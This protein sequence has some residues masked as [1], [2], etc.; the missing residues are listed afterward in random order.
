VRAFAI[1]SGLDAAV[2]GTIISVMPLELYR[3][4]GDAAVVSIIYFAVGCLSLLV[5][6]LVPRI[7]TLLQRRWTFTLGAALF[8]VGQTAGI[9]GGTWMVVA[10][11]ANGAG[12]VMVFV[13]LNAYVL[14]YIA[15]SDLGRTESMRMFYAALPWTVGPFLGVLLLEVWRPLPFIVAGFLALGLMGVFWIL[16]LG[17]G[18]AIARARGP[19]PNP[20]AYIGR[21]VQQP[22]LIAGWIFAVIRSSGWWV[23]AVYLPIFAVEAGL[24]PS[25]GGATLSA[26]SALM[27]TT[28]FMLRWMQARSV[29][30]AVRVGFMGAASCFALAAATSAWPW[31]AVGTM[32]AGAFFLVLLDAVG[33]L[34]FLLAVKPSERAEMAGIYS[35]FRD[36]SA[37]VTPGIAWL[38]LLVLPLPAMFGAM[39]GLLAATWALAGRLH[40]MLGQ[41]AAR[42]HPRKRKD[43]P[44]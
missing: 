22:R 41:P 21:F 8:L 40:P 9:I 1:L 17:N 34:P 10:I 39:G 30:V 43:A 29:R 5:G 42:R 14:D 32:M 4:F 26:A 44:A 19:E 33:G 16:R 15:R 31:I 36:V 25:I 13:C 2:R 6:L 7:A 11:L 12:T 37:I 20:L 18:R 28:P 3:A 27:F 38:V 23:F 24:D 35:S